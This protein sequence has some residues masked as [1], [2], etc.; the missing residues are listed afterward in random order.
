VQTALAHVG[1]FQGIQTSK[2]AGADMKADVKRTAR[3][4]FLSVLA[5]AMAL[6]IAV[7]FAAFADETDSSKEAGTQTQEATELAADEQAAED[8]TEVVTEEEVVVEEEV[9]PAEFSPAATPPLNTDLTTFAI[10]APTL[11]GNALTGHIQ[12]SS[13][14]LVA[15]GYFVTNDLGQKVTYAYSYNSFSTSYFYVLINNAGTIVPVEIGHRAIS[16]YT[17]TEITPGYDEVVLE[18]TVLDGGYELLVQYALTP[19]EDGTVTHTWNVTNK[20][21]AP[22]EIGGVYSLDTM[23]NPNDSVP[24]YSLGTNL[25]VFIDDPVA[26][27]R[28]T[29]PWVDPAIGGPNDMAAQRWRNE[30]TAED[31]FGSNFNVNRL[32]DVPSNYADVLLR[33]VDTA[34][35][36]RWDF[37]TL[38]VDGMRSFVYEVVLAEAEP[39]EPYTA[40][41]PLTGGDSA[42][43]FAGIFGASAALL[44]GTLLVVRSRRREKAAS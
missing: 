33:N 23:L 43:V 7:P 9:E 12:L 19:R 21:A 29:F 18:S 15:A 31:A 28:A 44:A 6:W 40:D 27:T 8:T 16:N 32:F 38:G 42:G 2:E 41:I 35:C 5:L 14:N 20:G 22:I 10:T 13:N 4:A 24:V 30:A 36:F 37:A 3:A 11:S 34:V 25:G 39:I 1:E 26:F 17:V